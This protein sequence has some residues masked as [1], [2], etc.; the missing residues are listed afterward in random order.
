MGL[1]ERGRDAV[2]YS[3]EEQKAQTYFGLF[4]FT[5]LKAWLKC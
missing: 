3:L 2:A 5:Q 4:S 1:G